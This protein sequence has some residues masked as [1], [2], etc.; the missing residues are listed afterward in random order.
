[1]RARLAVLALGFLALAALAQSPT[2]RPIRLESIQSRLFQAHSG[3]LSKPLDETTPLHNV[4]IGEGGV[5]EPST[6]TLVTV[7]FQGFPRDFDAR[8]RVEF[9][10]KE[11]GGKTIL[12]AGKPLGVL[13]D[14]GIY[15]VGFWLP[16]TGCVPIELT[17]TL[18]GT[19]QSK[20]AAL[21]FR[22][23]E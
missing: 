17:A 11:R 6:S 4:I 20:S 9:T 3:T 21:A 22:C 13:S 7:T 12:S 23:G 1:M 19:T 2:L 15:Q 5:S 8:W 18:R 10:A 16:E 14:K